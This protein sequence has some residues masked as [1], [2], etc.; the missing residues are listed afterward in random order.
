MKMGLWADD[1]GT[2]G[3]RAEFLQQPGE[4]HF[5]E[6]VCLKGLLLGLLDLPSISLELPFQWCPLHSPTWW[7]AC[8]EWSAT[9]SPKRLSC[10]HTCLS[11][12]P[13]SP[14]T[15]LLWDRQ[16]RPG[17]LFSELL[18]LICFPT[19]HMC[20]LENGPG[21]SAVVVLLAFMPVPG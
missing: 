2:L 10:T 18:T 5:K 1:K 17:P 13:Y 15:H 19:G 14:C 20:H 3:L 4:Y 21:T 16:F 8:P 12:S 11:R 9:S 6:E 7:P